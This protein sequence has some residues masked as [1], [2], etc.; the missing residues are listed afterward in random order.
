MNNSFKFLEKFK[1]AENAYLFK[2]Y[3]LAKEIL[4]ELVN[5]YPNHYKVNEL[6]AFTL[7]ALNDDASL[8]L[9]HLKLALHDTASSPQIYY[10]IGTILLNQNSINESINFLKKAYSKNPNHFATLHD[11][12]VA[13]GIIGNY[14]YAFDYFLLAEKIDCNSAELYY[15]I[16]RLHDELD[17]YSKS[18][19]FYKK[20][21]YLEPNFTKALINLGI[22][23]REQKNYSL[24]IEVLNRAIELTPADNYLLG[25][26]LHIQMLMCDWGNYYEQVSNIEKLIS[27]NNKVAEPFG[28]QAIASSEENLKNCASIFGNDFFPPKKIFNSYHQSNNKIKIGYVCGEFRDHATSQLIIGLF[29][30]HSKNLFEIYGFDTGFSDES[31]LRCRLLNS[32]DHY[33][34]L[35]SLSDLDAAKL[36]HE[37]KIDI[38]I[39]LNGYY[40]RGRQGIF[41]YRPSPIQLNYLGFPGTLGVNYFDYIIADEIVIPHQS[42]EFYFE[43][44]IYLPNTYQP[45]DP[46]KKISSINFSRKDFNLP[47]NCF[48]FCCF[49]NGYKITPDIFKI[50]IKLLSQI[51]NSVLWLY[52]DNY[53]VE[54]N[55]YKYISELNIPK[56]GPTRII[57]AEKLPLP[58]HLSRLRLADLFLD[59]F[60]YNAH[61]TASDSLWSGLPILTIRGNTFPS[62]VCSSLLQALEVPELITHSHEEYFQ[63]AIN[64]SKKGVEYLS[65]KNKIEVNRLKKPLF[66]CDQYTKNFEAALLKAFKL[67]QDDKLPQNI[68]PT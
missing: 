55:L 16:A 15:N 17:Q 29:E 10:L 39:Y 65:L 51:D 7:M 64:L 30:K 40:G 34:N 36:I 13:Y 14:K 25:M 43:K 44:I 5:T 48:V 53:F 57:F 11:L 59:T 22:A 2:N 33:I 31:D 58:D 47:E 20:C 66:D 35:N 27:T 3:Y 1:V 24:S 42:Q 18:I 63:K 67:H 28:Y 62:R 68:Y 32:F 8:I 54:Q 50:W 19:E 56:V 61:T 26:K 41:S 37:K 12:G 52:K 4:D 49:N 60:P 21:L 9:K 45:N 6:Y 38:L 46:E 23:Y